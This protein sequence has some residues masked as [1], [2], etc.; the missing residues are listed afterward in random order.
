MSKPIRHCLSTVTTAP[1]CITSSPL[2][3][4]LLIPETFLR[5]PKASQSL[6]TNRSRLLAP[7]PAAMSASCSPSGPPA[8]TSKPA[9]CNMI[10]CQPES[11][12][13][14]QLQSVI[15]ICNLQRTRS[16]PRGVEAEKN[17]PGRLPG[18]HLEPDGWGHYLGQCA[19]SRALL[20]G[21]G[22]L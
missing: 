18:T 4:T 8:D 15:C 9:P 14:S 5:L 12:C 21:L 13:S 19:P 17:P 10:F 11:K 20:G 1:Q 6:I 16:N 3:H 2:S 22:V 7:T